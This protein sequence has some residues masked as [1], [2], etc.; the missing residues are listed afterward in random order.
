MSIVQLGQA[1]NKRG[2]P[3]KNGLNLSTRKIRMADAKP[4]TSQMTRNFLKFMGSP[5]LRRH[6]EQQSTNISK[7]ETLKKT[8]LAKR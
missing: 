8:A 5:F 7:E 3:S 1:V 6:L 4:K 2:S